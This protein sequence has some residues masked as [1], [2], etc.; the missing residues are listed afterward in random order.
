M[1][2]NSFLPQEESNLF[3]LKLL[4]KPENKLCFDCN[5]KGPKW[6]SIPFGVFICLDCSSVHRNMGVH[7]TFARSTQ[8]DKWKLSQLKYMEYGGNL[9]AKQYFS[10]HGVSNNKIESKYQ[11]DAA[12]SYKQLLDTKVKKALKDLSS[13][14][15]S[16]STASTSTSTST[17]TN[18][19]SPFT[20]SP[21]SIS[22][23]SSNTTPKTVTTTTSTP[24]I[25]NKKPTT[26]TKATNITGR[27]VDTDDADDFDS[28][29]SSSPPKSVTTTKKIATKKIDQKSFDDDWDSTPDKKEEPVKVESSKKKS[30]S[31]STPTSRSSHKFNNDFIEDDNE[32]EFNSNKRDN[33]NSDS[34]NSYDSPETGFSIYSNSKFSMNNNNNNKSSRQSNDNNNSPPL[35]PNNSNKANFSKNNYS[36]PNT[37]KSNYEQDE[38]DYARK[39][40]SNAKSISSNQYYGDDKDGKVDADKQNRISKFSGATSISSAQYYERDETPTLGDMS[41]G[42]IARHLAFNA[43][44]DFSSISNSLADHG[45]KIQN[46]ANNIIN[47]LQD[48]YN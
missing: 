30:T 43:R 40:F 45:K 26:T 11:S 14:S 46:I 2:S 9:N 21:L 47:E 7:I 27:L 31:T 34:D 35:K 1:E 29:F 44:T 3:F 6:A 16:S 19:P 37:R 39:N 36:P 41:V 28:F 4:S 42:G 33:R 5:A 15:P 18:N 10:E 17:P 8:F 22:T 32:D 12:S 38:T 23:T 24:T 48:R 13:A 25:N 20:P